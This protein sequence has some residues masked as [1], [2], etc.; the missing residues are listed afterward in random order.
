[1]TTIGD[2]PDGTNIN[3][4]CGSTVP[5]VVAAE[6]VE[7]GADLGFAFDGDADRVIACDETGAIHDGDAMLYVLAT[8]LAARGELVPP[9]IAVTSMSNLGLEVALAEA[10]IELVRTDVGDRAVVEA[11]RTGGL[12]LGGEQ[13]GHL[14]HLGLAS[15]GDGLLSAALLANCV[16]ASGEPLSRLASGFERFPQILRNVEVPSKPEFGSLPAVVAAARRV[17]ETLGDHGR[18]V[19]RY[20]GTEPLARVMIEGPSQNEIEALA[21]SLATTI[22]AE[23]GALEG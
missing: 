4:N 19:L 16:A 6:T 2:R 15:T 22:A 3:R 10:G 14:V 7:S 1:M 23:I 12:L 5:G 13:S 18:L 20:S 21:E 9:R 8:A 11:L 17:E